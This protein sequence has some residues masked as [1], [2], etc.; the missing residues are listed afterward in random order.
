[1]TKLCRRAMEA[2]A[3]TLWVVVFLVIFAIML[4]ASLQYVTRQSHETII[5]EQEEQAFAAAEAGL[6]QALWL[7]NSGGQTPLNLAATE[8]DEEVTNSTGEV[9]AR[10]KLKFSD[11][12]DDH[13]RVESFGRDAAVPSVCQVV[14]AD[15]DKVAAGGFVISSWEHAVSGA[16]PTAGSA[17]AR[18]VGLP[19][20]AN[21]ALAAA[22]SVSYYQFAGQAG[23]KIRIM[24]QST[25]FTPQLTLY[26]PS[27][28][29]LAEAGGAFRLAHVRLEARWRQIQDNLTAQ[30]GRVPTTGC[31]TSLYILCFPYDINDYFVLPQD[32]NYR[33]E[34]SS[35]GSVVGQFRLETE[36]L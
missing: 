25:A 35:T 3:I 7:L 1:M 9:L 20:M 24:V 23:D 34:I 22:G 12:R 13:I 28:T 15:I 33:L 2:G 8:V 21:D 27:G 4:M 29:L 11:E 31:S 6:H 18:T 19:G 16:C 14:R 5:Q 30:L 36:K 32:G 17:A 26:A 10:Y